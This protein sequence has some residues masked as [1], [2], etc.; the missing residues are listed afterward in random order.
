MT[1]LMHCFQRISQTQNM[2]E[3][4]NICIKIAEVLLEYGADIDAMKKGKTI[5]MNFCSISMDLDRVSL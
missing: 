2:F 1:P 4:K 5:L 3:N